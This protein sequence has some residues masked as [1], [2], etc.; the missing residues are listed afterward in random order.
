MRPDC[1]LDHTI[2]SAMP[3]LQPRSF[4]RQHTSDFYPLLPAKFQSVL[5]QNAS[6]PPSDTLTPVSPLTNSRQATTAHS[7]SR[8]AGLI[9]FGGD[10]ISF[11]LPTGSPRVVGK[12]P[13]CHYGLPSPL[14]SQHQPR[15]GRPKPTPE[16]S[17]MCHLRI[18]RPVFEIGSTD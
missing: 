7:A 1:R 2:I 17:T 14:N 10:R 8:I 3:G 15:T 18:F 16:T 6:A 11:T 12:S 5:S 4:P 9:P 13:V